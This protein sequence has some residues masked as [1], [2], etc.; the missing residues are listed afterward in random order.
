MRAAAFLV[1]VFFA[2]AFFAAPALEPPAFRAAFLA[3]VGVFF[4]AFF[5]VFC[6]DIFKADLRPAIFRFAIAR[7][8]EVGPLEGP[9]RQARRARLIR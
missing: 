8:L 5:P 6:P 9:V 2:A 3:G 1:P 7:S 4:A